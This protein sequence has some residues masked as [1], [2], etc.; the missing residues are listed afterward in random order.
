MSGITEVGISYSRVQIH[1]FNHSVYHV[2]FRVYC[3]R[4]SSREQLPKRLF[5]FPHQPLHF[6]DEQ[7]EAKWGSTS[8]RL[9]NWGKDSDPWIWLN[10]GRCHFFFSYVWNGIDLFCF[11]NLF[12]DPMRGWCSQPWLHCKV[13]WRRF[14]IWRTKT[15]PEYHPR[16]FCMIYM[17]TAAHFNSRSLTLD[18]KLLHLSKWPSQVVQARNLASTLD[19]SLSLP[20]TTKSLGCVTCWVKIFVKWRNLTFIVWVFIWKGKVL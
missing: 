1:V 4:Q 19:S 3:Q 13:I 7:T 6:T 16:D 14:K 12:P 15:K 10:S 11:W 8:T 9:Q 5:F 17:H 18:P 20:S 2:P